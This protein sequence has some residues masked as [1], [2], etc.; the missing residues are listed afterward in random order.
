MTQIFGLFRIPTLSGMGAWS[1]I[2]RAWPT[3]NSQSQH[4][5]FVTCP[6]RRRISGQL[7]SNRRHRRRIRCFLSIPREEEANGEKGTRKIGAL[8]HD[9]EAGIILKRCFLNYLENKQGP[10]DFS[11]DPPGCDHCR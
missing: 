2:D 5:H 3:Q 8:R 1:Q 7:P 11:I 4:V 10:S 9:S 6:H